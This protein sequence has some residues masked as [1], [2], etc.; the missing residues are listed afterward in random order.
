MKIKDKV[1]AKIDKLEK[2]R[3]IKEL[4]MGEMADRIGVSR[5]SY[6]DWVNKRKLPSLDSIEKINEYLE[7]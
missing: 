7:G 2:M 1:R 4:N 5:M 3:E 6:S